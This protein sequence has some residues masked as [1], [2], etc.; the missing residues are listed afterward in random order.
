MIRTTFKH[1]ATLAVAIAHW[2]NIWK[3]VDF[4]KSPSLSKLMMQLVTI[5]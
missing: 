4:I 1:I 3:L 5:T 2:V